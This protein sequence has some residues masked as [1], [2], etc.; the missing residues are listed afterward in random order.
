MLD[1]GTTNLQK[2]R[3]L[4]GCVDKLFLA[5]PSTMVVL[6]RPLFQ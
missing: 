5:G 2:L 4:V 3:G 6:F 1:E